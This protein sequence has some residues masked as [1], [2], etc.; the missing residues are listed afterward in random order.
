M[1]RETRA[2]W[3]ST[4]IPEFVPVLVFIVLRNGAQPFVVV[5]E[6]AMIAVTRDDFRM[7][8]LHLQEAPGS[9]HQHP[10]HLQREERSGERSGEKRDTGEG[11]QR[12]LGHGSFEGTQLGATRPLRPSATSACGAAGSAETRR[13]LPPSPEGRGTNS[14]NNNNNN[15]NNKNKPGHW[16]RAES[17]QGTSARRHGTAA[18][19]PAGAASAGSAKFGCQGGEEAPTSGQCRRPG[20]AA[21]GDAC[22]APA[23][24]AAAGAAVLRL[25]P[26]RCR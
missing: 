16:G 21:P 15:N 9:D 6:I 25:S 7:P 12:L 4:Y 14:I 17:S 23:A 1:E 19:P 13:P 26:A 24:A 18:K 20:L 8:A 10:R 3:R 5:Q 2:K 11:Q 22:A